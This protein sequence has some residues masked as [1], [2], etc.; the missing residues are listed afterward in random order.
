MLGVFIMVTMKE[1]LILNCTKNFKLIAGESGLNKNVNGLGIF[2]YE[3]NQNL[4]QFFNKGDLVLTTLFFAKNNT[5]LAENAIIYLMNNTRISGLAIKNICFDN[6][7]SRVIECA[8][9]RAI[10]L[11]IFHDTFTEEIIIEVNETIK[12]EDNNSILEDRI[13]NIINENTAKTKVESIAYQINNFFD[14]NIVCAYCLEKTHIDNSNILK[15]LNMLKLTRNEDLSNNKTSILKYG[16][17]ILIIYSFD[18]SN[19]NQPQEKLHSIIDTLKIKKTDYFIGISDIHHNINELN[20]CIKKSIYTTT[21]C[22]NNN[23]NCL[24]FKDIGLDKV[25]LPLKNNYWMNEYYS[26][27]IELICSYDNKYNSD[28]LQ[29]AVSYVNNNGK[30][31]DVSKELFQHRNTVRYKIESI[32]RITNMIDKKDNFYGQL[33][34]AINLFNSNN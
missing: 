1:L 18:D 20:L 11:F 7:S 10:P 9:N 26:S 32:K 3:F 34:L 22:K 33:F 12:S 16:S 23:I 2:D 4:D 31:E 30:I 13:N 29:T 15:T 24:E 17:G 21:S 27:I 14:N 8:N 28:L 25:L 19:E 5:E 6:F